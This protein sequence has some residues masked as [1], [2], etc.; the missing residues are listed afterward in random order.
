M[1]PCHI[2]ALLKSLLDAPCPLEVSITPE[3]L[4]YNEYIIHVINMACLC[5]PSNKFQIQILTWYHWN[6]WTTLTEV[7]SNALQDGNTSQ[8][9]MVEFILPPI[10]KKDL[11]IYSS[12]SLNFSPGAD[13]ICYQ[14]LC[15]QWL[16]IV[17]SLDAIN[18]FIHSHHTDTMDGA[19]TITGPQNGYVDYG[20]N[21]ELVIVWQKEH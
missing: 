20:V 17:T 19:N 5:N 10:S 9:C 6:C 21:G 18:I 4:M 13:I 12:I 15:M 2:Q 3:P 16:C 7:Q 1:A 8:L 14:A 11:L